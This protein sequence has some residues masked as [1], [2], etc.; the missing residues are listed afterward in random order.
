MLVSKFSL[1]QT[2]LLINN[3]AY[4]I[5]YILSS[6][7]ICCAALFCHF[8]LVEIVGPLILTNIIHSPFLRY[9]SFKFDCCI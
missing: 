2:P 4:S 8:S 5:I 7:C 1:Y 6:V 3:I 9:R